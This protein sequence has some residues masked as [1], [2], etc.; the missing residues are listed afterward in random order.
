MVKG[1]RGVNEWESLPEF[2]LVAEVNPQLPPKLRHPT[3]SKQVSAEG[4]D[5]QGVPSTVYKKKH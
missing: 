4:S 5:A 2:I 3:D 1:F